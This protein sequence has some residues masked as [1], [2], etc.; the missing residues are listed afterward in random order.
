[1]VYGNDLTQWVE[2]VGLITTTYKVFSIA[3]ALPDPPPPTP[4]PPSLFLALAGIG[5]G[6]AATWLRSRLRKR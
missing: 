6:G 4:A 2:T 1:M 3:W 5:C